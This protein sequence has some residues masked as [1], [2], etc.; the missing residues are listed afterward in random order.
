MDVIDGH[1]TGRDLAIEPEQRLIASGVDFSARFPSTDQEIP[2][3]DLAK[4]DLLKDESHGP[5]RI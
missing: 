2:S 5:G 1:Q 3:R 4:P